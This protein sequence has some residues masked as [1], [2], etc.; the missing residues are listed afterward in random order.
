MAYVCRKCDTR[1]RT[2]YV[3]RIHD[4]RMPYIYVYVYVYACIH[5]YIRIYTYVFIYIPVYIYMHVHIY[6]YIQRDRCGIHTYLR[7]THALH[8]RDICMPYV[9]VY[10]YTY[11]HVYT[12]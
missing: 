1:I 8:I 11:L 6:M 5:I 2:T 4:V 7:R 9:Y 10:L 3:C 12:M